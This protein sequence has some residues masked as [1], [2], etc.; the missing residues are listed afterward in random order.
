MAPRSKGK[1]D[2]SD[3]EEM[4]DEVAAAEVDDEDSSDED[5]SSDDE[6]EEEEQ[7]EPTPAQMNQLQ[8][9]QSELEG[10][11]TAYEKHVEVSQINSIG[12]SLCVR[13]IR[14]FTDNAA[15]SLAHSSSTF[16]G[17]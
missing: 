8:A 11:P 13:C 15:C 2:L 4:E 1:P 9:L 12:L 3:D 16:S 7:V 6:S 14:V 17:S 10:N 5:D